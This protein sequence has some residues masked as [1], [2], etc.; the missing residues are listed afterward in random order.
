MPGLQSMCFYHLEL[1]NLWQFVIIASNN[2]DDGFPVLETWHAFNQLYTF[3]QDLDASMTVKRI[4][5]QPY[6]GMSTI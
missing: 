4:Y 1:P 2:E 6:N 5:L 3:T